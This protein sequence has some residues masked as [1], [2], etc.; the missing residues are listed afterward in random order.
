MPKILLI[1]DEGIVRDALKA[2]LTHAAYEVRTARSGPE[3]I[4]LLRNDPPD[5][6][7]LD[8]NLPEMSGS[9]VLSEIR[10]SHPEVRV[11]ILSGWADAEGQENYH[12][13]GVETILSKDVGIEILLEAV[14]R[15]LQKTPGLRRELACAVSGVPSPRRILIADDDPG[16]RAVLV[17]FLAAKGYRVLA[18]SDGRQALEEAPRF[19]PHLILLDINMP[20]LNGLQT[21]RRLRELN[22]PMGIF[23]ISG[24]D[25][26][27]IARQCLEEGAS[28]FIAKPFNLEYLELSAWAKI[29]TI[30]P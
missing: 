5:L 13:L 16:A 4:G 12:R 25:N 28:D 9:R 15:E 17:R 2:V 24:G 7:I 23:M 20:V 19:R 29:M 6:I 14:A 10:K 8:R 1:D 22:H 26:V 3:G 18:A 27:E 30:T 21:L 11:M